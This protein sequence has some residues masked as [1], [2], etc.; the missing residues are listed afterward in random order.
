M[1]MNMPMSV[2]AVATAQKI[3]LAIGALYVLLG[4][5][6][7]SP[8]V[9]EQPPDQFGRVNPGLLFGVFAVN[10]A[11]NVVHLVLGA[12]MIWAGMFRAQWD[13]LTRTIAVVL[14]ALVGAGF[15]GQFSD[16]LAIN[17][18]GTILHLITALAFGYFAMKVPDDDF[19]PT[20]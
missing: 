19:V 8:L 10:G 17:V 6:G 4:L 7:F 5:L 3:S 20:R 18:A 9:T 15:I 16:A 1:N 2:L 14:L 11:Q 12:M 13:L